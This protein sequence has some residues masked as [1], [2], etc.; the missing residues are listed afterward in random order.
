MAI[1]FQKRKKEVYQQEVESQLQKIL[2]WQPEN[3]SEF[4]IIEAFNKL[5]RSLFSKSIYFLN[6]SVELQQN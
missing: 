5:K 3:Y 2:L 6:A 4:K 1:G